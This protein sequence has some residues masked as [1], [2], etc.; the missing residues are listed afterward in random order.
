[1][2]VRVMPGWI[3]AEPTAMLLLLLLLSDKGVVGT[4]VPAAA[5][6]G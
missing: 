5:S 4:A 3:V 1:M 6:G 2:N